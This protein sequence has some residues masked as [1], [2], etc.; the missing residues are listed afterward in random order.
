MD[1]KYSFSNLLTFDSVVDVELG[2]INYMIDKYKKSVYFKQF[3]VNASSENV[4]KNLLIARPEK[5]PITILLR[6]ES[7]DSADS[8][9]Q[10]LE[11]KYM[12]DI[13]RFCKP[14]DILRF[15]KTL[16]STD[17]IINCVI[18][19]KN[20]LEKQYIN[21]LDSSLNTVIEEYDIKRFD[22]LFLKYIEDVI[23]Y[24]NLAGKYVFVSNYMHNIDQETGELNK[25]AAI[26]A[27][28]NKLRVVDPY[29]GLTLYNNIKQGEK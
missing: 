14:N 15:A 5:N 21:Q 27:K 26:I 10:E 11:E 29:K 25:I 19:C 16:E 13:L 22:C 28:Q 18:S 9:L 1:Q 3:V 6:E 4:K 7:K 12:E 2:I 17:G 20:E 23:K 8:L 24:K